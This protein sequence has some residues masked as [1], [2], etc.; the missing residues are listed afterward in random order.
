MYSAVDQLVQ[1]T[2]ATKTAIVLPLGDFLHGDNSS[3]TTPRSG[4]TLD[5]D[6]RYAKVLQVGARLMLGVIRKALTH[7]Q[8][9][10]VRVVRG[11][12][13]PESSTA[14]GLILDAYFAE[15]DRVMVDLSPS[16]FW[17]HKYGINL[18]GST[19]GDTSKLNDL[20]GVMAADVPELWGA[21][22]HRVW[23]TGHLHNRTITELTGGVTVEVARTLTP[24]DA[25]NHSKGFR[26]GRDLQS[27]VFH[28]DWGEVER[29]TVGIDRARSIR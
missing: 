8:E 25:W 1:S 14:L 12:H 17:Y 3:N 19:H 29:H 13:D 16:P 20:A 22:K 18:I 10:I 4:H 9:V 5:I 26:P 11:N 23:F 24:K 21:T 6:T 7:H 15:N 27:V 2:P 28:R